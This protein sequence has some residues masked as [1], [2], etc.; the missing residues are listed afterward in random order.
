[1]PMNLVNCYRLL[2]ISSEAKL[3]EI[4]ASYRRLARQYHPDANPHNQDAHTHF[5]RLTEAYK[6]LLTTVQDQ[7]ITHEESSGVP[8]TEP[9]TPQTKPE[10]KIPDLSDHEK[11]LKWQS[12]KTLCQLLPEGKF[13]R[14]IAIVEGLVQR[15]PQD[16]EVR[17]WQAITY[18]RWGRQL[19]EERQLYKAKVYLKKA[20]LAD[21][22]NRSLWAEVNQD[23]ERLQQILG[24]LKL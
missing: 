10:T 19:I 18:Q 4:K 8:K 21:P 6:F 14:A 11:H 7:G 15:L 2:G 22:N 20:L 23:F 9:K 5:M 3:K 16:P 24:D 1:M 17:Q 12:Y 13:A